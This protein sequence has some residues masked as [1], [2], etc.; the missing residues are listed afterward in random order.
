VDTLPGVTYE[1]GDGPGVPSRA[2]LSAR[3]DHT[4]L[5][6]EA[7]RD[8]VAREAALAVQWG[9]ASI[10]VQPELVSHVWSLV[11]GRLAVCSVVGFP[12]GAGLSRSKADEAAAAVAHGASEI[13]MVVALGPIADGDLDG[14]RHDVAVVREA[15]PN[16]L[17]KVILESALW[18]PPVLRDACTASV[19]AGADMVKT[20]TGFH[21]A[22]G[23]TLEAVS[24]MR[25][26]VGG[27]A[28]VKASGGLR[29]LADC[30]GALAAGA[31]RLG[32]SATGSVLDELPRAKR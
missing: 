17:L 10:C 13:D 16:V 22:G 26:A 7:T 24:T 6:P 20:S 15:V 27:R 25:S 8:E 32:L 12:H 5:R 4:I 18:A 11:G 19:D 2:E 30:L 9:C 1:G 14:V 29:S 23:A 3:I 21:P 28:G 31:D